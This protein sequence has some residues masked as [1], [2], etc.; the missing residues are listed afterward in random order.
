MRLYA[1]Y[2]HH[3]NR[4]KRLPNLELC[5]L[6]TDSLTITRFEWHQKWIWPA[7]GALNS[8]HQQP[9]GSRVNIG[10]YLFPGQSGN[11]GRN[12]AKCFLCNLKMSFRKHPSAC[13][14]HK[15]QRKA[16]SPNPWYFKFSAC[17]P[18]QYSAWYAIYASINHASMWRVWRLCL[19]WR[20][21]PLLYVLRPT[22]CL[23]Q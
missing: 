19:H 8:Q 17:P 9:K 15:Y 22:D 4:K 23:A 20:F 14:T 11:G 18:A 7:E 5:P 12:K 10:R 3:S 1:E 2:C 6:A 21:T 16:A 13:V